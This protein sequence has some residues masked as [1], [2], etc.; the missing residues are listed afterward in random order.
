MTARAVLTCLPLEPR[1]VPAAAWVNVTPPAGTDLIPDATVPVAVARAFL[2]SDPYPDWVGYAGAG[3]SCRLRAVDGDTGAELV[4]AI[5]F[6]P[7]FR[8]G[9]A[10]RVVQTADVHG[11]GSPPDALLVVLGPGGGPQV[12]Q[13]DFSPAAGR[14]ELTHSFFAPFPVEYRGGLVVSSGDVDGDGTP[15]ALFLPGAGGG[16]VLAAVDLRTHETEFSVFVGDPAARGP[17]GFEPTG[18]VIQ[19]PAGHRGVVVQYG[20]PA[21]D[22]APSRVWGVSPGVV[23]ADLTGEYAG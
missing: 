1:A 21:A 6:D 15:E 14:L 10:V 23:G 5:V 22:R 16:P 9:C 20:P 13:F 12:C 19:T 18:G 4:N 2:N 17:A 8:G 11:Y 7:A 3:G